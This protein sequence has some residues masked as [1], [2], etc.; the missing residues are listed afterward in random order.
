MA[1]FDI[2]RKQEREATTAP[3]ETAGAYSGMRVEVFDEEENL[4]FVA[5]LVVS[6]RDG[7]ELQELPGEKIPE[8]IE[9][10]HASIRGYEREQQLAIRMEA[11]IERI[12][13][14]I[15]RATNLHIVGKDNDRAFYRQNVSIEGSVHPEGG[16]SVPCE[17]RNVSTGG[18]CL[19]MKEKF[20]RDDKLR[21]TVR[22]LSDQPAMR[23]W[24]V[25]RRVTPRR[26][27]LTEYGC[28]FITHD[29]VTESQLSRAIMQL[30]M[31][32]LRR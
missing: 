20:A 31:K 15:W 11:D 30:Q 1:L 24:C 32:R 25:V 29:P 13:G 19:R 22:L 4:L 28:K 17:V 21:L 18:V 6:P 23:L 14:G 27:G 5:R 7:A 2:F 26:G 8:G 12:M 3:R 16:E 10:L 9:E